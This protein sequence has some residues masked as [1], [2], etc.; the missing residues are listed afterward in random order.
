MTSIK[1]IN[2][3]YANLNEA[4]RTIAELEDP[5]AQVTK[6]SLELTPLQLAALV[7]LIQETSLSLKEEDDRS[8]PKAW[9]ETLMSPI[10]RTV[11]MCPQYVNAVEK[12]RFV[13]ATTMPWIQKK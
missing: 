9:C 6:L 1:Q 3:T 11:A 13:M 2:Q 8:G 10:A 4:V 7:F 12:A 5:N